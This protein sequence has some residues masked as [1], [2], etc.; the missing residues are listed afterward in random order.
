M[1]L[2][3]ERMRVSSI[4]LRVSAITH[5]AQTC[6]CCAQCHTILLWMKKRCLRCAF[7]V[8][9][10]IHRSEL[11]GSD[12]C[13]TQEIDMNNFFEQFAG[14]DLD[15]LIECLKAVRV[16]GVAMSKHTQAG[17]NQKSDNVWVWDE[18]W[19]GCVACSPSGYV[20]W[21]HSCPECGAEHEFDTYED[22]QSYIN[23]HDGQCGDCNPQKTEQDEAA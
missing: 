22:L 10:Y 21:W 2:C 11:N 4:D 7:Y 23:D 6:F 14:A 5:F 1:G 9:Q 19:A 20:Q 16:A 3:I 17:I 13:K 12:S 15:R 8:L 18:E